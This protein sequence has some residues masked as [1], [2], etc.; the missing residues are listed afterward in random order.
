MYSFICMIELDVY[1]QNQEL[2][3]DFNEHFK[4]EVHSESETT[5]GGYLMEQIGEIP[6]KGTRHENDDFEFQIQDMQRHRI[7]SVIVRKKS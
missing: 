4:T 7:R 5:L 1:K 3:I 6:V 2:Y